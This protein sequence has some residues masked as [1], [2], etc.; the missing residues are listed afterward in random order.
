VGAR[1]GALVGAVGGL[2]FVLVNAGA[3]GGAWP[4]VLRVAAVILFLLAVVLVMRAPVIGSG[5]EPTAGQLRAYRWTVLAEVL[6]FPAGTLVLRS[7]L[8]LDDAALPWVAV[9]VGVHFVVF[10][11]IFPGAG[12]LLLGV[13]VTALGVAGLSMV[14]AGAEGDPVR[15]VA[16]VLPGFALLAAVV[17]GV[18]LGKAVAP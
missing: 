5:A 14:V 3:A 16:G 17:R 8:G 1:T 18:V 9:V 10:A 4:T 6:A 12:F 11:R 15:L 2:V 7:M 13:V